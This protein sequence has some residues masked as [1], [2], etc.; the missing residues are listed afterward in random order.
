[1]GGLYQS[2]ASEMANGE[3]TSISNCN[4]YKEFHFSAV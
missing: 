1:M 2:P 4:K 3:E